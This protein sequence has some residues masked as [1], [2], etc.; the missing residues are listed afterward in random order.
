LNRHIGGVT[1]SACSH[2]YQAWL[3][4]KDDDDWYNWPAYQSLARKDGGQQE[5]QTHIPDHW[6]ILGT[7]A[8]QS[9][10]ETYR[11]NH[12]DD[13]RWWNERPKQ[14]DWDVTHPAGSGYK[15]GN[16]RTSSYLPYWHQS[17][18]IVPNG[19]LNGTISKASDNVGGPAGYYL[20]QAIR[21]GLLEA[22]YNLNHKDNMV[23]LPLDGEVSKAIQLPR[24]L[25]MRKRNHP[26]YSDLVEKNVQKI[27]LDYARVIKQGE[28]HKAPPNELSKARLIN[29]S[30]RFRS[31]IR[32]LGKSHKVMAKTLDMLKNETS[33]IPSN[34]K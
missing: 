6:D 14:G 18:H 23:I 3:R 31:V 16:F 2:R 28:G 29:L 33:L 26:A 25:A 17:H 34:L 10:K 27:I 1:K 5:F 11:R 13:N 32:N 24:H 15:E 19:V 22:K 7:T 4:A 9:S 12:S 30:K 21:T 8:G 20:E